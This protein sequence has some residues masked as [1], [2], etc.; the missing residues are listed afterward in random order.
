MLYFWPAE[1]WQMRTPITAMERTANR[2]PEAAATSGY[3]SSANSIF[4]RCAEGVGVTNATF[5]DLLASVAQ[6]S[7]P[8]LQET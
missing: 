4:T 8:T 6:Q 5:H 7:Q 2:K 1:Q 3:S